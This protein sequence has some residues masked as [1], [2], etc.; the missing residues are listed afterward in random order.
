MY[1]VFVFSWTIHVEAVHRHKYRTRY[2]SICHVLQGKMQICSMYVK[3]NPICCQ[4]AK[5]ANRRVPKVNWLEWVPCCLTS[6]LRK[7]TLTSCCSACSHVTE[8]A[9]RWACD[10]IEKIKIWKCL[11]DK[12]EYMFAAVLWFINWKNETYSCVHSCYTLCMVTADL[13]Y[14][15]LFVQLFFMR[16][17]CMREQGMRLCV[18]A[19]HFSQEWLLSIIMWSVNTTKEQPPVDTSFAVVRG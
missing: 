11:T 13:M 5:T 4:T 6:S 14:V 12:N 10:A 9:Q 2:A 16:S 1:F 17:T 8:Q 7:C 19:W 3:V 15:L 18:Y